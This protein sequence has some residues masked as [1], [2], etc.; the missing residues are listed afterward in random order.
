MIPCGSTFL[1]AA[2]MGDGNATYE[3]TEDAGLDNPYVSR[4]W[5]QQVFLRKVEEK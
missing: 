5:R 1:A 4:D 2:S 3:K